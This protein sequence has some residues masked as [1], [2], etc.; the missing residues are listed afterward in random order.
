MPGCPCVALACAVTTGAEKPIPSAA[1][2]HRML[3]RI[4]CRIMKAPA[5]GDRQ[6][7]EFH[8]A[9]SWVRVNE[10]RQP[11]AGPP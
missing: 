4:A 3:R 6:G 2:A 9:A 10:L 5:A 11:A 7:T 8:G 1:S